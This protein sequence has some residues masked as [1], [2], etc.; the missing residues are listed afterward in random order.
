MSMLATFVQVDP[1]LL[2]RLHDESDLVARLFVP[3]LPSGAGFDVERMRA[4][5]VERGPRLLAGALENFDPALRR[6]IEASIGRTHEALTR[7][8]GGNQIFELLQE[9]MG[10][11]PSE[12]LE[13]THEVLS[14]DKAWHGVH[15]LL[16]GTAELEPSDDVA[17]RAVLGGVEIGDDFSGY[18][19]ARAFH[20]DD[21]TRLAE[22]LGD[23]RVALDAAA[24]YDAARMNGLQIYPFGWDDDG[25]EW[26]LSSLRELRRFYTDG[27]A[28][29]CGVLTCLV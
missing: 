12:P 8:E 25:R 16:S 23:S 24:R 5:V 27:A 22:A 6:Q 1:A 11:R 18:G 14:L 17:S 3:E 28:H 10:S 2:D 15:Y 21:V 26:L 7:G 4:A 29:G 13:G 20:S 9:Q 19:P